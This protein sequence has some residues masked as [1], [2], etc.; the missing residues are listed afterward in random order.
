[1]DDGSDRIAIVSRAIRLITTIDTRDDIYGG[2]PRGWVPGGLKGVR[3]IVYEVTVR[4][5]GLMGE[6][7][8]R[9][10]GRAR[11]SVT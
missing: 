10:S 9:V 3:H 4:L 5:L 7:A 11:V 6:E 2:I 8:G 1:M